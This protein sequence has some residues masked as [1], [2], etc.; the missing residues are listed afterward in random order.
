MGSPQKVESRRH[1][2]WRAYVHVWAHFE[3]R[4]QGC[5][6]ACFEQHLDLK[7]CYAEYWNL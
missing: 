4:G 7:L 5:L 2:T 6:P 3:D 1:A